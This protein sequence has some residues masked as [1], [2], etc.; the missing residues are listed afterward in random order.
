[1]LNPDKTFEFSYKDLKPKESTKSYIV[2]DY[3]NFSPSRYFKFGKYM[4]AISHFQILASELSDRMLS[5]FLDIDDNINISFHIK[6]L[7]LIHI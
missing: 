1:M 6:S 4:G 5:E 7:S 2:P 3:F